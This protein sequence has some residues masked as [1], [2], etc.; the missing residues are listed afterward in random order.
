MTNGGLHTIR[1]KSSPRTGSY[2]RAGPQ[3]PLLAV[4]PGGRGGQRQR[5][6][7]DVGGHHGLGMSRPGAAP[8]C[9]SRCRRRARG[10]PARRIT[11]RA[12]RDGRGADAEDVIAPDRAGAGVRVEVGHQQEFGRR[13]PRTAGCPARRGRRRRSCSSTP[14]VTASRMPVPRRASRTTS[15]A[16]GGAEQ[17][18]SGQGGQRRAVPGGP[19]CRGQLAAAERP[20]GAGP[21]QLRH[22]VGVVS[23]GSQVVAE[24]V[25]HAVIGQGLGRRSTGSGSPGEG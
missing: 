9:R 17:E 11:A 13:P 18:Q 21:E 3:V 10:P 23:G 8:G 15:F 22:P 4:Q 19:Q 1:S 24:A 16:L 12:R 6:G 14:W 20:M 25:Q 5:P 2:S 7:V